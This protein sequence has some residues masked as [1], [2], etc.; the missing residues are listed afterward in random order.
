LPR[1]DGLKTN[2]GQRNNTSL[3]VGSRF[4]CRA[5]SGGA[6]TIRELCLGWRSRP[7]WRWDGFAGGAKIRTTG[8]SRKGS[9]V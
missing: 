1:R 2:T 7:D 5:G 9:A 6:S 3:N 4:A 8:P